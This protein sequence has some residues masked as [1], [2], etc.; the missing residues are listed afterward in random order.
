MSTL[1]KNHFTNFH[2][3]FIAQPWPFAKTS[4]LG[5]DVVIQ[6]APHGFK[7]M[8]REAALTI[9]DYLKSIQAIK[10]KIR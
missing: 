6:G 4:P 3:S 10:N 7:D 9:A 8:R 5:E 2:V 1:M